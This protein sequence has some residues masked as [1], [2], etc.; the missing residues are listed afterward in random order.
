MTAGGHS[1]LL[2]GLCMAA[3]SLLLVSCM[4][5][6]QRVDVERHARENFFNEMREVA[7][8]IRP[9]HIEKCRQLV[10]EGTGAAKYQAGPRFAPHVNMTCLAF[11]RHRSAFSLSQDKDARV[12]VVAAAGELAGG[13]S[14]V[15]NFLSGLS[16]KPNTHVV[17][18]E[19]IAKNGQIVAINNGRAYEQTK[20]NDPCLHMCGE[21]DE[22]RSFCK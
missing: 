21:R 11:R 2:P 4:T 17:S 22:Y 15:G 10:S 14:F 1:K 7:A 19:I 20:A 13:P 3:V 18:C 9:E 6:E 12:V 5:V 8:L 16:G